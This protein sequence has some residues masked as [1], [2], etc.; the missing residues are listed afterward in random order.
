M[1]ADRVPWHKTP[2]AKAKKKAYDAKRKAWATPQRKAYMK[3]WHKANPR[4]RSAYKAAYDA[5]HQEENAAYRAANSERRK[6]YDAARYAARR[7]QIIEN[8]RRHYVAKREQLKAYGRRHYAAN[9]ERARANA[10]RWRALN[11][12]L[13]AQAANRRRVRKMNN[14]GSHTVEE[15][16]ALCAAHGHRCAYC[17]KKR[18][19]TRD[20]QIPLSR[21]GTDDIWNI[22]PACKSCNSSKNAQT[23]DEFRRTLLQ[24]TG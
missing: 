20:H 10:A 2:E 5:N 6:A 18:P 9:I 8:V 4:D 1:K 23:P 11:P 12:E 14:G 19:L 17:G 21:G 22:A 13:T 3:A 15:W 24:R 7:E 16:R